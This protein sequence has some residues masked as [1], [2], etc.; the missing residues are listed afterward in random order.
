MYH[1]KYPHFWYNFHKTKILKADKCFTSKT[2]TND[3]FEF[4]ALS[5]RKTMDNASITEH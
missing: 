4:L 1:D 2:L 3:F 5:F